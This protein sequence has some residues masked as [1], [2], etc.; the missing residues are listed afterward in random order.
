VGAGRP[1][2]VADLQ[3]DLAR[4]GYGLPQ[5]GVMDAQ[6]RDV[7]I[8]FQRHFRPER[9]DGRPDGATLARLDALLA[10]V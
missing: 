9:I 3:R 2:P 10:L 4:Y 1:R 5:S 8:A 6:T 7:L